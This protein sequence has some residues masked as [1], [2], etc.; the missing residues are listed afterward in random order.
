M[1]NKVEKILK[2]IASYIVIFIGVAII[3]TCTTSLFVT[4]LTTTLDISL[5][6]EQVNVAAKLTFANVV[7]L[8]I[9]IMLIDEL[10]RRLTIKRTISHIVD[11]TKKVIEGDFSVRIERPEYAGSEDF[12]TVI[13]SFNKMTEEL[14]GVEA[15]RGDFIANVSHEM[16]TPLSVIQNY[17]RL[18]SDENISEEQRREYTGIIKESS[19]RLSS[20][21][22]N[23]LKLN[24]L[25]NQKI[26]PKKEKFNLTENLTEC[27]LGFESVWDRKNI[28]LETYIEDDVYMEADKE[29]LELVWNNLFSNAFKF[30]PA[31]GKV[32]VVLCVRENDAIVRVADTG[33]GMT[34]EI[35]GRIF[36]K[37][38]QG[39]SSHATEGNGL[40]L[41][42]VKRV[43]DILRGE[44][45]VES[46]LG[47]GSVFTVSFRRCKDEI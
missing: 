27:L 8:S 36:D 39:D 10:R 40:G 6:S 26:F 25:E 24:R 11:A 1:S 15:L 12:E 20:M 3:V 16:K 13:D 44:I 5:T 2:G 47:E 42:L 45:Y 37:F 35:G 23:I 19:K 43:V 38:Y 41:A 21:I 7:F 17:A 4:V 46:T 29:L 9:I 31:G 14:A 34:P 30:T 18:L 32:S 33:C 22:T 28:Y